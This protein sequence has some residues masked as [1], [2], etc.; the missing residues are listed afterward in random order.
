MKA[1]VTP[2][3]IKQRLSRWGLIRFQIL[4]WCALRN[5]QIT[6]ADLDM[7]V[8]LAIYGKTKL[9]TFCE[10]LIKT[11]ISTGPKI[12][13]CK[14]TDKEY[15]YIFDSCQSARNALAKVYDLGLILRVGKNK[16]NIN[17][18]INPEMNIHTDPNLLVNYQLL[19]LDSTEG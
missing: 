16:S 6:N 15:K 1:I 17:I 10:D 2:V 14:G 4:S 7:L 11:E 19:C 18:W 12:K 5:I 9:A 13:K 8:L 3:Q